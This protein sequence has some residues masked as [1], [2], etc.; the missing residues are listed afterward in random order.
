MTFSQFTKAQRKA[1]FVYL[2]MSIPQI[3]VA[4]TGTQ[5]IFPYFL[6]NMFVYPNYTEPVST[7]YTFKLFDKDLNEISANLPILTQ[8][9]VP[10]TLKKLSTD[11]PKM[12]QLA[13]DFLKKCP[14]CTKFQVFQVTTDNKI[15]KN[16]GL[17]KSDYT[18]LKY[19]SAYTISN[20]LIYEYP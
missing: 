10:L 1:L 19:Q 7:S 13:L 18:P 12:K 17:T 6:F 2:A 9:A 15:R 16:L 3:F 4:I 5:T 14:N 11:I 20:K 8:N